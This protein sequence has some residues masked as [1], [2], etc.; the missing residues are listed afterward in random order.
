M[1]ELQSCFGVVC[2]HVR[3]IVLDVF[4][5]LVLTLVVPVFAI[6]SLVFHHWRRYN[7]SP[8]KL[9]QLQVGLRVEHPQELINSIQVCY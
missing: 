4:G 1:L 9:Y 6:I 5:S 7:H 8:N 2:E 3:Y